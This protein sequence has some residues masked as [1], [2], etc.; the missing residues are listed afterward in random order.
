MVGT[1]TEVGTEGV[2]AMI[3]LGVVVVSWLWNLLRRM[4]E[5]QWETPSEE[6]EGGWT[7]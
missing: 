7:E 1:M 2:W 5:S 6:G 3:A 4:P